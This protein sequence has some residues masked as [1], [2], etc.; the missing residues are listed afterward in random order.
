MAIV[1]LATDLRGSKTVVQDISATAKGA[2][3][4]TT[5]KLPKTE[6]RFVCSDCGGDISDEDKVCPHCGAAIEGECRQQDARPS[7]RHASP[8]PGGGPH[9]V[10]DPETVKASLKSSHEN[11]GCSPDERARGARCLKSRL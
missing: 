3:T 1:G 4:L 9:P 6:P 10:S 7:P 2:P 8:V 5:R 11:A